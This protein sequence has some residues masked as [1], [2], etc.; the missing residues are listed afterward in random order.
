MQRRGLLDD[1]ALYHARQLNITTA[2]TM[3]HVLPVHHATGVQISFFPFL[4]SG[5][6]IEFRSGSFTPEW[7]WSRWC[8]GGITFF[9]GVPTIYA[10]LMK[11]YNHS[12]KTH[13]EREKY[14][15]GARAVQNICGTSALPKPVSE[16]WTSL[17]GRRIAQRYGSTECAVPFCM[18]VGEAAM[19]VPDG[20]VGEKAWGVDVKLSAEGEILVKSAFQFAKYLDEPDATAAAHTADGYFK[21]GDIARREGQF[22]YILGR[23]SADILKSGGYKISALDIEREVMALPYVR[24]VMVVGVPDEEFGQRVAAVVCVEPGVLGRVE[25]LTLA[26]LRR[27]LESRLAGYKRPTLLRVVSQAL[28]R[29]ASGKVRKKALAGVFFP[30]GYASMPGVQ[31]WHPE[32]PGAKL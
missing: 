1:G 12:L 13:P 26:L 28:P 19:A 14:L 24:E 20:S 32:Q 11:Y 27:D 25:D 9:S 7:I 16:F 21:T 3:L 31:V 2:D 30:P 4:L 5:A 23:A 10:R 15:T 6:T 22:Y 29:T 18:P 8:T 17:L